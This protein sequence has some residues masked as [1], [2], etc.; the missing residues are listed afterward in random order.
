MKIIGPKKE[1]KK[2]ER[3]TRKKKR[4]KT[5]KSF[6]LACTE[7]RR[8]GELDCMATRAACP[9][10]V[11]VDHAWRAQRPAFRSRLA[12]QIVKMENV[13]QN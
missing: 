7:A 5:E 6:A 12:L 4:K 9:A 13:L 11:T 3:K 1:P 10:A 2:K 8:R